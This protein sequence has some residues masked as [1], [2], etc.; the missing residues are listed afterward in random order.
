MTSWSNSYPDV[1][2]GSHT[3][4][5]EWRRRGTARPGAR[6]TLSV[7]TLTT[8]TAVCWR[9]WWQ[10]RPRLLRMIAA[11]RRTSDGPD[12]I[13]SVW[14]P[15]KKTRGR[16][17]RLDYLLTCYRHSRKLTGNNTCQQTSRGFQNKQTQRHQK[18][19]IITAYSPSTFHQEIKTFLFRSSFS[20]LSRPVAYHFWHCIQCICWTF[21]D[22]CFAMFCSW[23]SHCNLVHF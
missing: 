11:N 1:V 16:K 4:R 7:E 9:V 15:T 17:T 13:W 21:A 3:S 14:P 12:V 20:D 18:N 8:T 5:S 10:R 2:A 19:F 6:M 23:Q 22:K